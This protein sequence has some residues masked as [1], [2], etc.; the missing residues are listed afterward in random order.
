VMYVAVEHVP[1]LQIVRVARAGIIETWQIGLVG[2]CQMQLPS[3]ETTCQK[4]RRR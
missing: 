4:R 2:L 3:I 1:H